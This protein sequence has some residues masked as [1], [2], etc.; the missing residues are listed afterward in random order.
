MRV[1]PAV[2]LSLAFIP[3]QRPDARNLRPGDYLAFA[4]EDYDYGS[5]DDPEVFAAVESKATKVSLTRSESKELN[6]KIL[7]WPEQFADRLQ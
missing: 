6:L 4:F 1:T 5:L 3:T 2:N 7:P